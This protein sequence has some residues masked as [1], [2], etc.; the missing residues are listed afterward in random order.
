MRASTDAATRNDANN[1]VVLMKIC[2][3]TREA[4]AEQRQPGGN[5]HVEARPDAD[6]APMQLE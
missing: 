3:P 4:Q 5:Q 1:A 6:D 2:A